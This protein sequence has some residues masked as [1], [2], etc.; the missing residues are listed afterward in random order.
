MVVRRAVA[1]H[2]WYEP[3]KSRDLRTV[4]LE[5]RGEILRAYSA[6]GSD[7]QS[8]TATELA[9]YATPKLALGF[10]TAKCIEMA[11][12]FPHVYFDSSRA[13][14]RAASKTAYQAIR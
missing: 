13:P 9:R 2:G 4:Q 8:P 14:I 11:M 7:G 1:L 10:T 12:L 3:C 5:A 6:G